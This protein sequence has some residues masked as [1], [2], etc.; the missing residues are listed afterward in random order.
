MIVEYFNATFE[1]KQALAWNP[2]RKEH[3]PRIQRAPCYRLLTFHCDVSDITVHWEKRGKN[4]KKPKKDDTGFSLWKMS[5]ERSLCSQ[6][7]WKESNLNRESE[8]F[9]KCIWA[10]P[11]ATP[12][13]IQ[14]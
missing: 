7:Y 4:V 1:I 11:R 14:L 2:N 13:R 9:D 10:Y 5:K 8:I 6:I 3:S 12:V